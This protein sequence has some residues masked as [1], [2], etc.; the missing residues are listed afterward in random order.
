MSGLFES[1]GAPGDL[2]SHLEAWLRS[3]ADPDGPAKVDPDRRARWVQGWQSPARAVHWPGAAEQAIRLAALD[4]GQLIAVAGEALAAGAHDLLIRQAPRALAGIAGHEVIAAA[5]RPL[6]GLDWSELIRRARPCL[7]EVYAAQVEWIEPDANPGEL[8]RDDRPAED[9][10]LALSMAVGW[11]MLTG[12][13]TPDGD[14]LL[15]L[16]AEV[17]EVVLRRYHVDLVRD[18]ER[19]LDLWRAGD[20]HTLHRIGEISRE[21]YDDLCRR[22]PDGNPRYQNRDGGK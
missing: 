14:P 17:G 11:K 2:E 5:V 12:A 1:P 22:H 3:S 21:D 18:R 8:Q 7:L 10:L 20:W 4:R 9:S 13:P 15:D 6:A 16:A 19:V